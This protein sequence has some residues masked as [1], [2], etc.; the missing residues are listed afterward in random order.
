MD[1]EMDLVESEKK[2]KPKRIEPK[3]RYTLN[4]I[5]KNP[6]ECNQESEN[7][8]KKQKCSERKN[9]LIQTDKIQSKGRKQVDFTFGSINGKGD[10]L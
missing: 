6:L 2:E 5:Y 1:F 8:V 7:S 3:L 10:N 9:P 4:E